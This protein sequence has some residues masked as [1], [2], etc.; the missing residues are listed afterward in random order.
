MLLALMRVYIIPCTVI[1]GII[2]TILTVLFSIINGF[3]LMR[4]AL[5]PIL[6]NYDTP[7]GKKIF[8]LL[9]CKVRNRET[10][11]SLVLRLMNNLQ[12]LLMNPEMLLPLNKLR[13]LWLMRMVNA[14]R[15]NLNQIPMS[16]KALNM[17]SW[18]M[19]LL[20]VLLAVYLIWLLAVYLL[21]TFVM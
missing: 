6:M 7:I 3:R 9:L 14:I 1:I 19:V 12:W 13:L 21:Q 4:V 2:H 10:L 8:S 20:F 5:I 17:L 15:L 11:L 16:L 18:I